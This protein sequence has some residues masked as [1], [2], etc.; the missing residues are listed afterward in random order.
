MA[1]LSLIHNMILLQISMTI[2]V[3]LQLTDKI[4]PLLLNQK[5][6]GVVG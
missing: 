4:A 5:Y 6:L 3:A 1:G 2:L